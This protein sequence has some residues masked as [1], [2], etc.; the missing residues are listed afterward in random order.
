MGQDKAFLEVNGQ[1]LLER[2]I[3]LVR[4]LGISEIFISGRE[5]RDYA[6]HGLPVLYDSI[7]EAG[8]L[9]GVERALQATT[10]PLL[11]VLAVDMAGMTVEM[12]CELAGRSDGARGVIPRFHERIEPLAA[13]YPKVSA[14]AALAMLIHGTKSVAAFAESCVQAQLAVFHEVNPHIANCFQSWNSPEDIPKPL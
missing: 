9:G 12:L 5:G 2:Q 14:S 6:A 8:P 3:R 1:L 7:P 11:L 10:T 4:E 13:I